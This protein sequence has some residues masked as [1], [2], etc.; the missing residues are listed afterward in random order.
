MSIS[1]HDESNTYF[2]VVKHDCWRK[3]IQCEIF[4]FKSDQTWK[5]TLLSKN[6]IVI[7]CKWVFKI[8]NKANGIVEKY[9]EILVV[10]RYTQI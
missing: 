5:T 4:A 6:K 8:K 2:V 7:G 9:K 3:A 10:K 1:S